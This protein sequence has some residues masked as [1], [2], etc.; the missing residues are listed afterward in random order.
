[1]TS[2]K[3]ST[4]GYKQY[5]TFI[6]KGVFKSVLS[7][8]PERNNSDLCKIIRKTL[9]RCIK[10]ECAEKEF[11]QSA[12]NCPTDRG[13]AKQVDLVIVIDTSGSMADEA[14][15]L[16]NAAEEAIE[17]ATKSC[18][19]NLCVKW[20]GIEDIWENTHFSQ[21]YRGYLNGLGVTDN[22]LVGSVGTED[23]FEDGAAAIIDLSNYFDWRS[24]ADRVIFYLGDEGL[25]GGNP[26]NIIDV[27]ARNSAI[28]V[29]VNNGITVH[30]YLG[31]GKNHPATVSDYVKL[32]HNTGGQFFAAPARSLGGFVAV[33]ES[34]I[35]AHRN[36]KCKT[37]EE[38]KV[39]PCLSLC[40]GDGKYDHLET[41][42]TEVLCIT[43]SNPYA[44]I[45]LK[46][47]TLSLWITDDCGHT[48]AILPNGSP[49]VQIKPEYMINFGNI[50]PCTP[51]ETSCVSR[52]VVFMSCGAKVGK[53][54]VHVNYCF[55]TCFTQINTHRAFE[56]DLVAS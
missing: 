27:H 46:N 3:G 4:E 15:E 45:A 28:S 7:R 6:P 13:I 21:S 55:E 39:V 10:K 25:A 16:S 29:A 53:Y 18:D 32:A 47:F 49:S 35:C 2:K 26:Q 17:A 51:E 40:W 52:E 38:P 50:V 33:L 41:T 19:S 54:H 8:H 37:I 20:F 9:D 5:N 24:G 48:V 14:M 22:H 34:I 11:H 42:D 56:L 1:M 23:S 44:N 31:T 36:E 43:V 30:T 12:G